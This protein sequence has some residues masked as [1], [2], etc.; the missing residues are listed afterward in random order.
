M[1]KSRGFRASTGKKQKMLMKP[2]HMKY[3][4][5]AAQKPPPLV[6]AA[7]AKL[8]REKQTAGYNSERSL[9]LFTLNHFLIASSS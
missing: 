8:C 6:F 4:F 7:K 9:P 3:S 5:S 2:I 1:N